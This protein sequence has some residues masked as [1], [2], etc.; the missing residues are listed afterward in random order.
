MAWLM[1]GGVVA[2]VDMS[3]GMAGGGRCEDQVDCL[4]VGNADVKYA[5]GLDGLVYTKACGQWIR[6]R[7]GKDDGLMD[8]LARRL[9]M[10]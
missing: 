1:V 6:R 9:W 8:N 5:G 10:C 7:D 4:M 2:R 3:D